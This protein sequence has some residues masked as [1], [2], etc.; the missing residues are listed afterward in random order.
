MVPPLGGGGGGYSYS[1]T[2]ARKLR[3]I[4]TL[5]SCNAIAEITLMRYKQRIFKNIRAFI[6]PAK[7]EIGAGIFG[8]FV[9]TKPALVFISTDNI[10]GSM[11]AALISFI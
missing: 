10:Q 6:E 3:C 5:N 11:Q 1:L 4:H 7:K 2:M 8:A 9:I